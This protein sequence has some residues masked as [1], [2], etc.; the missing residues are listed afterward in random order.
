MAPFKPPVPAP[1]HAMDVV[2]PAHLRAVAIEK[3]PDFVPGRVQRFVC[4]RV[5]KRTSD[6]G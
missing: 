4:Q 5:W 1:A 2:A 3:D 6:L